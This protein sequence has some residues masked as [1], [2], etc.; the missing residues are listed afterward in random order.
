MIR[1]ASDTLRCLTHVGCPTPSPKE[2]FHVVDHPH[3]SSDH[4]AR[5]LHLFP[6][7]WTRLRPLRP[8]QRRPLVHRSAGFV[9][10]WRDSES[11]G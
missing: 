3:H 5:A 6:A 4:R 8:T 7:P 9:M 11:V 10:P 2:P 1:S